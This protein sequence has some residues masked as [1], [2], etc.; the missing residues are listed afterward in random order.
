MAR[1]SLGVR[2]PYDRV[3]V[4]RAAIRLF[5]ERGYDGTSMLH[6]ARAL[7]IHKSSLY[8]HISGKEQ[9]LDGA[10][11]SAL[12]ALLGMLDEAEAVQGSPLQRLRHVVRRTVQIMVDQLDEVTVLLRVRGNTPTE[13]WALERRREFDRRVQR[14]VELAAQEGEIRDDV[15]AALITRLLFGMS[16]SITEWYQPGRGMSADD[17]AEGILRIC[18]DGLRRDTRAELSAEAHERSRT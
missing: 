6:I 15:D 9:I 12:E 17:I 18:F 4:N 10:V 5:K 1:P 13:R 14:L 8:H 16:N 7:G 11:R 3:Q 2:E